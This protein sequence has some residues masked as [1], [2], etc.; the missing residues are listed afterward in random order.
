MTITNFLYKVNFYI[1]NP[2]IMLLFALAFVYFIYGV[3]KFLRSSTGD[4]GTER[5][6]ARNSIFWGIVGMFVMF[7]V[8]A[9][10]KFVLATFGITP[11]QEVI[12][13]IKYS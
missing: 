8:Y 2:I 4:K 11:T 5:I 6:E 7:S 13:F 10:I 9:L 3:I 1:L 12:P